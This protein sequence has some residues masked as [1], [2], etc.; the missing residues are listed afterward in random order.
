MRTKGVNIMCD[1]MD[2]MAQQLKEK[3]LAYEYVLPPINLVT[4]R[5]Y[6]QFTAGIKR[7]KNVKEVQI[8]IILSK[9]PFCGQPY[10]KI[11]DK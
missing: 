5:A 1:C 11:S 6:L 8:P 4:G 7:D 3:N 10:P 2:K 9:C